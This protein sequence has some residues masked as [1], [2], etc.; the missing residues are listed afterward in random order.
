MPLALTHDG[1]EVR[2]RTRDHPPPHVH[3]FK[4]DEHIKINIGDETE[5]PSIVRAWM[6]RANARKAVGIVEEHQMRLL[7]A[8]REI[9]G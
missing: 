8:W 1:F 7:A 2:I 3:V 6:K 9:Y 4:A 5:P